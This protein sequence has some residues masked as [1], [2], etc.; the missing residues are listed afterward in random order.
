M[1][2]RHLLTVVPLMVACSGDKEIEIVPIPDWNSVI[3]EG[4]TA[5]PL[6]LLDVDNDGVLDCIVRKPII[7]SG[8]MMD[9]VLFNAEGY[10][11]RCENAH[12]AYRFFGTKVMDPNFRALATDAYNK[13][14]ALNVAIYCSDKNC[15]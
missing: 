7:G 6:E 9:W 11:E 15:M 12:N 5:N 1:N 4:P 3:I 13:S 10:L 8:G 14:K 2:I